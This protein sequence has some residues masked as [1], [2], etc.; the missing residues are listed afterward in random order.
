MAHHRQ[1]DQYAVVSHQK[2]QGRHRGGH[3]HQPPVSRAGAHAADVKKGG[4]NQQRGEVGIAHEREPEDKTQ[5]V[6]QVESHPQ[7]ATRPRN[8]QFPAQPVE[9]PAAQEHRDHRGQSQYPVRHPEQRSEE[10]TPDNL[11]NQ[12]RGHLAAGQDVLLKKVFHRVRIEPVVVDGYIGQG[13]HYECGRCV[14]RQDHRDGPVGPGQERDPPKSRDPDNH[15][16]L[17]PASLGRKY[18]RFGYHVA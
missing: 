3:Q 6:E 14:E 11:K 4:R 1:R 16:I 12:R 5:W 18:R 17:L 2:R 10:G 8:R 13:W 9:R 7:C 15:A